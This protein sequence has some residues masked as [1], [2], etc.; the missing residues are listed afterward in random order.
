MYDYFDIKLSQKFFPER[1][2]KIREARAKE[3]ER[4]HKEPEEPR[5]K[6]P[7]PNRF[8]Q[9]NLAEALKIN[10]QTLFLW[11]QGIGLPSL[12]KA[13]NLCI[14]L[15]CDLDYLLGRC[16]TYHRVTAEI[17]EATGLSTAAAN[18]LK[19]MKG[20]HEG[21]LATDSGD[22]Y[23]LGLYGFDTLDTLLTTEE[24][25]EILNNI[26]LYLHGRFENRTLDKDLLRKLAGK[27][28]G[29][30]K[31]F[32]EKYKYAFSQ[33]HIVLGIEGSEKVFYEMDM[34]YFKSIF[35]PK[36]QESLVKLKIQIDDA[37][38]KE[39][40]EGG[41]EDGNGEEAR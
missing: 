26:G 4:E 3:Y 24:G 5:K 25:L 40:K 39:K 18:T 20:I 9:K 7:R 27:Y 38:A 11:E 6:G 37:K 36:V 35:L 34:E 17:S 22:E 16:D 15:D 14:L 32:N 8:S 2:R 28:F 23:I 13:I 30:E 19:N 29:D 21:E 31:T 1:L 10:R 33:R 41:S 12:E